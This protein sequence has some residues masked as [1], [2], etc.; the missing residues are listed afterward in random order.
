MT[1]AWYDPTNCHVSTNKDDPLFT[2][3]GQ[4]WP[5]DRQRNWVGLTDE[6]ITQCSYD[7]EG[8]MIEREVAMAAVE[9]KLKEKNNG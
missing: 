1:L 6:E 8:F 7:S 2:P 4:L 5:V 9:A 3:L